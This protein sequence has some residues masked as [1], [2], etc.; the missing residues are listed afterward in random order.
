L[1]EDGFAQNFCILA[2]LKACRAPH[3]A[4]GAVSPKQFALAARGPATQ[5]SRRAIVGRRPFGVGALS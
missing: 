4:S 1:T 3:G 5:H 2:L